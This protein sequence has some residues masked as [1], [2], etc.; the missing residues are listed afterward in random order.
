MYYS[1]DNKAI[2][3]TILGDG[4]EPVAGIVPK[5]LAMNPETKKDFVDESGEYKTYDEKK[6]KEYLEK[7]KKELNTTEF[8]FD[9]LTDDNESTKKLAEYLQGVFKD[10]LGVKTTVTPVTKPIRL[11][12]TTKGDFDMV[13]TGWGADYNDVSSF[14][15]LFETGN[16]YN[17]GKYTNKNYDKL[18]QDAKV[19]HATDEKARWADYLA[20][21][22]IL[23]EEDAAVIPVYQVVEGHL[24]NPNLTGYIAHSAGASYEYKY[25]EMK[26]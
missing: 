26:E 3:D 21:E 8:S 12:R 10:K 1:V 18:I 25:L 13:V 22:K 16:S 9:I 24:R 4:S 15:D 14:L 19:A 20:A 17:K 5:T 11:D 6:A 23:L 7:A 2:V